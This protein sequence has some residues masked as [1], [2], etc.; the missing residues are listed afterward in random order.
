MDIV[1]IYD[2]YSGLVDIYKEMM[3]S[4][5]SVW[6]QTPSD[7]LWSEERTE[8]IEYKGNKNIPRYE[9]VQSLEPEKEFKVYNSYK[10]SQIM[11][12]SVKCAFIIIFS[13]LIFHFKYKL[14]AR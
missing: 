5:S 4:A 3:N 2:I 9:F 14:L 8:I 10:C 6:F 11:R 7:K 12:I 1:Y 13:L